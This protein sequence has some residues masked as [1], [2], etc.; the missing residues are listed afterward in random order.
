MRNTDL[1]VIAAGNGSRINS[2]VPK[3]LIAIGGEPCLTNT[4]RLIG[5]HFRTIFVVTNALMRDNWDPYFRQLSSSCPGL[6]GR[7]VN[8]PITSGMGDG[9]ATLVALRAASE[10]RRS[11]VSQEVVVIWGDAYFINDRL[12]GELLAM[13]FRGSGLVPAIREYNPY[14]ALLVDS[15]MRC[16]AA[17]FSKYGETHA[18]GLHDQSVFRFNR[19]RLLRSLQ[20]LHECSWKN[21][22]YNT[23]SGELSLLF[24]F[25]QLYNSSDPVLVYETPNSTLTFNTQEEVLKIRRCVQ[26]VVLPR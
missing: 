13:E 22:R 21:G 23:A 6:V 25:H 26:S 5:G 1:Y 8:L 10:I 16:V 2:D 3:A 12:I 11:L 7:V 4:L 14:V 20:V 15:G 9:H 19:T 24:T 18:S 17:D